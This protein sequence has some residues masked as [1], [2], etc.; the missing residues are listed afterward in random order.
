MKVINRE[1][2]IYNCDKYT[3]YTFNTGH[4]FRQWEHGSYIGYTPSGNYTNTSTTLK[5]ARLVSE[6]EDHRQQIPA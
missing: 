3:T 6:Y 5:L 1:V 4:E 2:G